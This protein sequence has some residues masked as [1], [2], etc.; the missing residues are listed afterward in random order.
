MHMVQIVS[1]KPLETLIY[2]SNMA[3]MPIYVA[4]FPHGRIYE[5]ANGKITDTGKTAGKK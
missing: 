1:S 5:V 3:K 2:T 4:T